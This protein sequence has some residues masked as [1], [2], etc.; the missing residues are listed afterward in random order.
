MCVVYDFFSGA[1]YSLFHFVCGA[2]CV[3]FYLADRK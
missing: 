1:F 3:R 2:F